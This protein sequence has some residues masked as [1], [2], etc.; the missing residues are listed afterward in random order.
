[1]SRKPPPPPRPPPDSREPSSVPASTPPRI[2]PMPPR[3]PRRPPGF[4]GAAFCCICR[5]CGCMAWGRCMG[6][7]AL[8]RMAGWLPNE[9]PPPR[10]AASATS[11][12]VE[13][14][15]QARK[16][17][18]TREAFTRIEFSTGILAHLRFAIFPL[19][20]RCR[21]RAAENTLSFLVPGCAGV[22]SRVRQ[23]GHIFTMAPLWI[24]RFEQHLLKI[25][26][27]HFSGKCKPRVPRRVA[28]F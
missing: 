20:K 9:R 13:I 27:I 14:Q 17:A 28:P 19:K 5:C 7:G 6:A 22:R 26:V 1:M 10:R 24:R 11:G 18:S 15:A 23:S 12:V 3:P 21:P 8:W 25:Y 4:W 16:T 2:P